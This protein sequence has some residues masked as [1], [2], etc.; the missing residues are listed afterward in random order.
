MSNKILFYKCLDC[1]NIAE[2]KSIDLECGKCGGLVEIWYETKQLENF[3]NLITPGREGGCFNNSLWRYK[4]I[5]PIV[6][7]K[8]K[9]S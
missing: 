4:E 1:G 3:W 2:C 9:Q 6:D 5:M 7:H 8:S